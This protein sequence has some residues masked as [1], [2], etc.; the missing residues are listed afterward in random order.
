LPDTGGGKDARDGFI[1]DGPLDPSLW[2]N[3]LCYCVGCHVSVVYGVLCVSQYTAKVTKVPKEVKVFPGPRGGVFL[4]LMRWTGKIKP[5]YVDLPEDLH[6]AVRSEVHKRQGVKT[7]RRA[8]IEALNHWLDDSPVTPNRNT[9]ERSTPADE[10][11][12]NFPNTYSEIGGIPGTE[13]LQ[14]LASAIPR[15]YDVLSDLTQAVRAMQ[16][17]LSRLEL[18][19][20][21]ATQKVEGVPGAGPT[22]SRV[23]SD[24][25]GN[26]EQ[27]RAEV[28]RL[29]ESLDR[30]AAGLPA[31]ISGRRTQPE[32]AGQGTTQIGTGAQ[33]NAAGSGGGTKGNRKDTGRIV[34]D[35]KAVN[36]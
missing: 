29:N 17:Q 3:V 23:K 27:L 14:V 10:G 36:E 35:D 19:M 20:D 7:Y 5:V 22:I 24:D 21:G 30:L 12:K 6:D 31:R 13:T 34:K 18:R 11:K 4:F 1:L 2:W 33:G 16:A 15:L 26:N 9:D 32:G 25:Q 8:V 28:K